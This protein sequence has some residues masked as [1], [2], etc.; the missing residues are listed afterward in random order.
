MSPLYTHTNASDTGCGGLFPTTRSSPVLGRHQRGVL[1]FNSIITSPGVSATSQMKGSAPRDCPHIRH[2]SKAVSP[3]DTHTSVP[4]GCKS[5]FSNPPPQV[6]QFATALIGLRKVVYLLDCQFIV[7][8]HNSGTA[9]RKRHIGQGVGKGL[10][11]SAPSG[12]R[13]PSTWVCSPT[14]KH[15][16]LLI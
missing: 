16:S 6:R 8:G 2:W 13:P 1:Q 15:W 7:E 14:L 4:L 10:G 5:G 12:H 3:Q 9:R 11:A